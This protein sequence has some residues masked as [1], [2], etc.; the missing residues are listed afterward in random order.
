[1]T[2]DELQRRLFEHPGG[3][4]TEVVIYS[5]W[6]DAVRHLRDHLLSAPECLAWAVVIPR[7]P[8]VLD[9]H[10]AK[11]RLRYLDFAESSRG[12]QSQPLYDL[13]SE[14]ICQANREAGQFQ[15]HASNGEITV[16]FGTSGILTVIRSLQPYEAVVLTAFLPGQGVAT[17][18]LESQKAEGC[19]KRLP[20]E[21]GM[22]DGPGGRT[23]IEHEKELARRQQ[24]RQG[25]SREQRLYYDV[26]RPALQFIRE[27]YHRERDL[28]GRAIRSDY[29]LLKDK[30]P[31]CSSLKFENW[32][33][34]RALP[35]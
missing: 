35:G 25:F 4:G 20:R 22:R 13:Y 11:A 1:M 7:Y 5:D 29:A 34:L 31:R 26:F 9:P 3:P 16:S 14:A 10:D 19:N 2:S 23:R 18:T 33:R 12:R 27:Q 8:E 24:R 17:T 15:W 6:Q 30:L 28:C 32:Q 21:S